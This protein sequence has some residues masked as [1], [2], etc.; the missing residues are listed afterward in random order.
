VEKVEQGYY[1]GERRKSVLQC[2]LSS[3]RLSVLQKTFR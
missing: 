2:C 1:L 3:L